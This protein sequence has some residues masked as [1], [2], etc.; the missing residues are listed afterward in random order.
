MNEKILTFINKCISAGA[1]EASDEHLGNAN[2]YRPDTEALL[3]EFLEITQSEFVVYVSKRAY[4]L[5]MTNNSGVVSKGLSR[6]KLLN[7][8]VALYSAPPNTQQKLDKAREAVKKAHSDWLEQIEAIGGV[9][10][11]H[12]KASLNK[13][14]QAL[15]EIE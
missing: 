9:M 6:E 11:S 8:D 4:D 2:I 15:K 10:S 5:A 7:D 3:N 1:R 13:I 14:E 12:E